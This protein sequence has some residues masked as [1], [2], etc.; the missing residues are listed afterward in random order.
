MLLKMLVLVL[1]LLMMR[2]LRV[3]G[4][5]ISTRCQ[6]TQRANQHHPYPLHIP[7]TGIVGYLFYSNQRLKSYLDPFS[8]DR[9]TLSLHTCIA[10][11][12]AFFTTYTRNN[13]N[14]T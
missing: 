11:Q 13:G 9:A 10:S 4:T 8:R 2:L 14:T 1:L 7:D 12:S 6:M 3:G 5:P